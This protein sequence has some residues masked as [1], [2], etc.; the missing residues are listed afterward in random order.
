MVTRWA[1]RRGFIEEL[2]V[3]AR[4]LQLQADTLFSRAPIRHLEVYLA[5]NRIEALAAMPSLSRLQVLHL[6][7]NSLGDGE[8]CALASSP[9]LGGL[10][11]LRLNYNNIGDAGIEALASYLG[12]RRLTR[13]ELRRNNIG[14]AG[15]LALASR[16]PQ[17][18]LLEM[19]WNP[20]GEE[21]RRVLT[22]RFGSRVKV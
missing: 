22:E 9:H 12:L 11:S 20:L 19:Y 17:L 18:G 4:G 16:L 3:E 6:D 8:V 5:R 1:F 21:G 7:S 13:L 10:R 2:A 15:A 14:T